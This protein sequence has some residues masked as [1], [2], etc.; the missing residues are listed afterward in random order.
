[1]LIDMKP[2][3]NLSH[4]CSYLR[5]DSIPKM[6]FTLLKKKDKDREY[7]NNPKAMQTV[8]NQKVSL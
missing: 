5:F 6:I 7:Q 1:M 3:Q 2:V 8:E 4:K